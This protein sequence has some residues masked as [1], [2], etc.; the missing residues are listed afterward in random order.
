MTVGLEDFDLGLLNLGP[1]HPIQDTV[2]LQS[3]ILLG[4][5]AADGGKVMA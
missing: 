4:A 2:Q 5:M 1:E 3:R